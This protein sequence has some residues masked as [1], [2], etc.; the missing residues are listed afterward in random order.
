MKFTYAVDSISFKAFFASA[1]ET[2]NGVSAVSVWMTI[3]EGGVDTLINVYS[4]EWFQAI[5]SILEELIKD[6]MQNLDENH[7]ATM[8]EN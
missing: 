4:R 7:I 6:I 5:S 3:I 8:C 1:V 2:A